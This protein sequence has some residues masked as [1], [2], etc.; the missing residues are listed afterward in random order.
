MARTLDGAQNIEGRENGQDFRRSTEHRR[1]GEWPVLQTEHRT[2]NGGRMA[3]TL[4]TEHRTA[5]EWPGL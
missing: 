1:A 5:G 4:S 2:S 3:R